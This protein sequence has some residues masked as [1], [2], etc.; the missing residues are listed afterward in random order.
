MISVDSRH[1]TSKPHIPIYESRSFLCI[2]N[3]NYHIL[4]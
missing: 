3:N 1:E 2:P 4:H